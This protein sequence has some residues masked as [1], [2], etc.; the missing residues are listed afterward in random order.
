MTK[1]V[2]AEVDDWLPIEADHFSADFG[3]A[4]H[5]GMCRGKRIRKGAR[6]EPIGRGFIPQ[7]GNK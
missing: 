2:G 4:K 1:N 7:P 3:A 5:A 6:A